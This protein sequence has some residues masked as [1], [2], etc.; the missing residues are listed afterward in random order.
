MTKRKKAGIGFGVS[1]LAFIVAAI[2]CFT[3]DANPDWMNMIFG[4]VGT[5]AGALGFKTVF[6]DTD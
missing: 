4:I 3:A 6:P 2:V 5:V 1:G